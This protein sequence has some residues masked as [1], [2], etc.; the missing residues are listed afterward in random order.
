MIECHLEALRSKMSGP[1]NSILAAQVD[2]SNGE[3]RKNDFSSSAEKE[4]TIHQNFPKYC[5]EDA[6]LTEGI[7][8]VIYSIHSTNP[9]PD[10]K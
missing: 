3:V 2:K 1:E 8:Q 9:I 5:Q 7:N 6:H 10:T 4:R